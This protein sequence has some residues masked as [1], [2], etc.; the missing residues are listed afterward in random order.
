MALLTSKLETSFQKKITSYRAG[1]WG[2]A[3]ERVKIL[4]KLGYLVDCPVTPNVSWKHISGKPGGPGGI[5]YSGAH[6]KVY[7]LDDENIFEIGNSGLIEIP[8]TITINFGNYVAPYMIRHAANP[9][10]RIAKSLGLGPQWFRPLPY[11]SSS[12]MISVAKNWLKLGNEYVELMLHSSELMPGGS[13][14]CKDVNA[15]D[16][17]YK[18][19]EK[20]F[21]YLRREDFKGFTLKNF[22]ERINNT[23]L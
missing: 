11:I 5:D 16:K 2:L 8:M 9:I 1:R 3:A 20:V 17:L 10:V 4:V 14:Y 22:A 15:V 19:L 7:M 23:V 18:K 12:R 13:P 21:E 6:S